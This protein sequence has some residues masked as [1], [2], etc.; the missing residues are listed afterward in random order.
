MGRGS[1]IETRLQNKTMSEKKKKNGA[2]SSKPF[3]SERLF[4]IGIVL[5]SKCGPKSAST[6]IAGSVEFEWLR[7]KKKKKNEKKKVCFLKTA[8]TSNHN[9][10]MST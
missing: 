9:D 8:L 2:F 10:P 3:H 6:S 7:K 1:G 4:V 5:P